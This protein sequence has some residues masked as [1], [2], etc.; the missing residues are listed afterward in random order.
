MTDVNN[1]IHSSGKTPRTIHVN[2][3]DIQWLHEHGLRFSVAV[4]V[5]EPGRYYVRLAIKDV[6]SGKIG[7]AYQYV[8]IPDLKDGWLAISDLFVVNGLDDTRWILDGTAGESGGGSGSGNQDEARSP[9]VRQYRPGESIEYMAVIYNA[10][11]KKESPPDLETRVML[12]RDGSEVFKS[13]PEAVILVG[14][15]DYK[16]IPVKKSFRLEKTIQPGY[17]VLQLEVKDKKAK[18]ADSLVSGVLDF[19]VTP[20]QPE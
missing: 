19:E 6:N 13:K 5:S 8:E 3:E 4:P 16:N 7:S 2:N 11:I 12:Y 20:K 10:T 9:A 1:R 18:K 15:D 14:V 17:Y